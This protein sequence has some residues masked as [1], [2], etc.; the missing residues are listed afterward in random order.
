MV[1]VFDEVDQALQREKMNA[2]W[3]QY[4]KTVIVIMVLTVIGTGINVWWQSYKK[5]ALE[6]QTAQMLEVLLPVKGAALNDEQT[7]A[8]LKNLQ[9]NGKDQLDVLAGLQ[10]ASLY[11]RKGKTKEALDTL[12]PLM[13]RRYTEKILQDLAT[14]NYVR[15]RLSQ[16][17]H[18]DDEAKELLGLLNPL[19]GEKRPFRFSA[20]E[21]KGLILMQQ[22]KADQAE[23]IFAVLAEDM[24]VPQTLRD[25]AQAYL[26]T[27]TPTATAQ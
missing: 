12:K 7:I 5:A 23:K 10:L 27:L 3:K 14:V 19:T 15:L 11:E 8:T 17:G 22:G 24:A 1:D 26:V 16:T 18:A 20:Q 21:L 4:G 25:R 9:K 13:T 2:W 6:A